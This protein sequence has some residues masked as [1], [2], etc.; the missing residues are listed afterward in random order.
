[1]QIEEAT[2]FETGTMDSGNRELVADGNGEV[3]GEGWLV[4]WQSIEEQFG[5][6]WAKR[7]KESNEPKDAR[8]YT[9]AKYMI[10]KKKKTI[11][12]NF[13]RSSIFW[14]ILLLH[15]SDDVDHSLE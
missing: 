8:Y 15:F 9:N 6:K 11:Y 12:T 1:M 4:W 14:A 5:G 3:Y 10:A 2:V 13:I 7:K